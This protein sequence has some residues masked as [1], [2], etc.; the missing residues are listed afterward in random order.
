M[1]INSAEEVLQVGPLV[2]A[3]NVRKPTLSEYKKNFV[4]KKRKKVFQTGGVIRNPYG[5]YSP[6]DI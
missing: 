3:K 4:T 2:L 6:R 5:D 1:P